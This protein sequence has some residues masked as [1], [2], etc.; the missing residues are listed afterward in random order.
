MSIASLVLGL[1]GLPLCFLFIPSVLAI[2][3][4]FVGLGQIKND[5]GQQGRGLAIAGIVLGIVM[6]ALVLLVFALGDADFTFE[7][8]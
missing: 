3:F 6:I 7:R 5:P 1:V 8:G 2:I 4:G